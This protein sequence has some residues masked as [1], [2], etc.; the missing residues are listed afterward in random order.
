MIRDADRLLGRIRAIHA[1][2]RDETLAAVER[3]AGNLEQLAAVAGSE[4]GDTIYA[5]DRATE[6]GLLDHFGRLAREW[7]LL[8]VAEGL[9]ETGQ[10]VLPRGAAP[11]IAVII[12]PIDGTRGFM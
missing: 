8:L 3:S 4:G 10:A 11:E 5:I 7:P 6:A 12:D 2:L 9:G 1:S